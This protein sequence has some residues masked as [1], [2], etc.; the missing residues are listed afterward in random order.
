[1]PLLRFGAFA[2]ADLAWAVATSSSVR[3][4]KTI[5]SQL[6]ID[7]RPFLRAARELAARRLPA[8]GARA[9]RAGLLVAAGLVAESGSSRRGASA[10]VDGCD[11]ELRLRR[12]S[13][14]DGGLALTAPAAQRLEQVGGLAERRLGSSARLIA[15]A[16]D[17][18]STS[19]ACARTG[20]ARG[21]V[22]CRPPSSGSSN[23][24]APLSKRGLVGAR[25][26]TARRR[27]MSA[28]RQLALLRERD[29]LGVQR[30]RAPASSA[31]SS[32]GRR[33]RSCRR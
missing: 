30:V 10:P 25:A 16:G 28:A 11:G 19:A 3:A 13:A 23:V 9:R 1:M 32:S 21:A 20:A 12:R 7:A 4:P 6:G 22:R 18:G 15:R 26:P 17:R 8:P 14:V 27:G 29:R 5:S 31:R 33:G 2:A 24:K